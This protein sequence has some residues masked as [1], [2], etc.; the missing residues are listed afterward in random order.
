[1]SDGLRCYTEEKQGRRLGWVD[2]KVLR[3][4]L[5]AEVTRPEEGER[6]LGG[7]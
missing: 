7:A 1:M 3:T 6:H 4:G 2:N 5:S